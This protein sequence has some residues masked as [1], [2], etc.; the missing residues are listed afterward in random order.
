M[1][2]EIIP[3]VAA[4]ILAAICAGTDFIWGKVFNKVVSRALLFALVWLAFTGAWHSFGGSTSLQEFPVLGLWK[5]PPRIEKQAFQGND[6]PGA[7]NS[8]AP[9]SVKPE[10]QEEWHK[11]QQAQEAALATQAG[12]AG[13][14]GTSV[15][16]EIKPSFWIYAAK[17]AINA[18]TA[19]VIGMLMWWFGMWAA[20][21]AKL[22]AA[23][24]AMLPLSSYANSYWP[25]FPAYVLIFN[26]FLALL[27]ILVGELLVRFMKLLIK[28]SPED[29]DVWK[30]A[31]SWVRDHKL[32]ILR[33][34]LGILFFMMLIK[35]LRMATQDFIGLFATIQ[36]S[37]L[38]YVI[39]FLIFQPLQKLM[40]R[41][42]VLIP[43]I[44]FTAGFVAHAAIWPSG[45][46]NVLTILKMSGLM[47]GVVGFLITYQL[48]LNV[49][50]YRP[51]RIWELRPQM[52]LSRKTTDTLKEDRDM[53]DHKMGPIGPD[54]LN[55]Q[56]VET[57]RRWWIDRGKGGK[58]WISRTI[59]FAPALLIGT[60][61][62]VLLSGYI[63]RIT[64]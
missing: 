15:A 45:N 4:V 57:L 14:D 53:L 29:G 37:T 32:D 35:T 28:P 13:T 25:Y 52:L 23:L 26:S 20:G 44:V 39:L 22:F 6:G 21:D 61:L 62:T 34:F 54:G 33:G 30:N 12:K 60:I 49:F 2:V 40:M 59:P 58:I 3:K 50:D 42:W 5:A 31:L 43:A 56:Q 48:Y 47:V 38:M 27:G 51:V 19:L 11:A 17:M 41:K 55:R 8:G 64:Y 16:V 7:W 9:V 63:F 46:H 1:P 36:D 24:V 10:T 18:L